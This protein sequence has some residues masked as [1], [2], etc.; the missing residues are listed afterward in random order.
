M[1][2]NS[3]R[4]NEPYPSP[5]KKG[6]LGYGSS[7]LWYGSLLMW[8]NQTSK[9]SVKAPWES[10]VP[11]DDAGRRVS[12]S[13]SVNLLVSREPCFVYSKWKPVSSWL[14]L[15]SFDKLTFVFTNSRFVLIIRD[16]WFVL[17]SPLCFPHSPPR[18]PTSSIIRWNA[19]LSWT[20]IR[21]LAEARN[22]SL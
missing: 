20:C 13:S 22:Y 14:I 5:L 4:T 12:I 21:Q 1:L 15:K 3:V 9:P 8:T 7:Q 17:L 11:A 2:L 16:W 19:A 6:G 10:G 18:M